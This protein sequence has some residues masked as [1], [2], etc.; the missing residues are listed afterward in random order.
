[1]LSG[2]V[3]ALQ[4][5]YSRCFSECTPHKNRFMTI[6]NFNCQILCI[7]YENRN[8][9]L[10]NSGIISGSAQKNLSAA[11]ADDLGLSAA[12][13]HGL[14]SPTGRAADHPL[15]RSVA[16]PMAQPLRAPPPKSQEAPLH[17]SVRG[18]SLRASRKIRVKYS[19]YFTNDRQTAAAIRSESISTNFG[20][21]S[22]QRIRTNME[23]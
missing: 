12:G 15:L 17:A 19:R 5:E 2:I 8:S 9:I 13:R 16:Q 4:V 23:R 7:F 22:R 21:G 20:V 14:H 1:M 6:D 3:P 10:S 11:T 18:V